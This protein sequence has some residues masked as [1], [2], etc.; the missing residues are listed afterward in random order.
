[1]RVKVH[2]WH[3][4][5]KPFSGHKNICQKG[6]AATAHR[7]DRLLQQHRCS[8]RGMVFLQLY[9]VCQCAALVPGHPAIAR[10]DSLRL[11][12]VRGMYGALPMMP[13]RCM[14]ARTVGS[15][16]AP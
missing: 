1:M 10:L 16:G 11:L 14:L 6:H 2:R 5:K 12:P 13:P 9:G 8:A 3:R 4:K 7:I 15:V